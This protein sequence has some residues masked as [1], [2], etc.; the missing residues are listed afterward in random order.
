[1]PSAV[2]EREEVVAPEQ[3]TD[4]VRSRK[5]RPNDPLDIPFEREQRPVYYNPHYPNGG[6]RVHAT[7]ED[8]GVFA[9]GRIKFKGGRT[10]PRTPREEIWTREWVSQLL[11]GNNPDRWKGDDLDVEDTFYCRDCPFYTRNGKVGMDHQR[12]HKHQRKI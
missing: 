9:V 12:F 8:G 7:A 1:M 2:V 3:E 10:Q 4:R 5:F 6:Y 11:N